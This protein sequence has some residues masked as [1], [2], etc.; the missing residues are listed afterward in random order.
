MTE[1]LLQYI[2]QFQHF[3]K[4]HLVCT[5]GEALQILHPGQHNHNQGPDFLNAKIQVGHT[6]WA[7]NIELHVLASDWLYHGHSSDKNY[8]NTILHV[9][10]RED[11]VLPNNFYTLV[12]NN[13]VAAELLGQ[14]E[15]WMLSAAFVPC[16][17]KINTVNTL[18]FTAWKERL[19]LERLQ[20][21]AQQVQAYLK[22]TENHWETAFWWL[23]ARNFGATV[24]S[25]AFEKIAQTIPITLLA[26]TK[27]QLPQTEALL[28]GQAGLLQ[29]D[30]NESYPRLLTKE[31]EFLHHKH[32]LP[33]AF[34]Q[35]H[36]LRMRPANFPTVRLAQLAM[37]IH[38]SEHL[39][40]KIKDSDSLDAVKELLNVT[41]GEYWDTH[42]LLDEPSPYMPKK[43]GAQM[44]NNLLINTVI[45]VVY[46]YG[47]Y[48]GQ[49]RYTEK[50]IDWM[51]AITAEKN[52]ITK[53]FEA[54]GIANQSA[55]DSQALIQLKNEYCNQK[56]C[57]DC[58][59]GNHLLAAQKQ[60]L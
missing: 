32:Q 2:W 46:A 11:T 24:N 30:F 38:H 35:L 58:A 12:L 27:G 54:L 45:P 8:Q 28:L 48:H 26:R 42:Y 31:F 43:T 15:K 19:L 17:H 20:Q 59:V 10:W 57:L 21:K 50:A 16:G 5:T 14:Y 44:V 13:R 52:S 18:V 51:A 23:L 49:V 34:V 3:N 36:F 1:R 53:G 47:A 60:L 33:I 22:Q 39:F 37:L 9:V 7:G 55:I 29:Q 6:V 40:A 4:A 56:R 25:S 41:A